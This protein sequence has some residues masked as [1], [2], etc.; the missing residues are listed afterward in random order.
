MVAVAQLVER[1]FVELNVAGS[2]PVS[3]P[4]SSITSDHILRKTRATV[5]LER[6]NADI[7]T[8]NSTLSSDDK[9]LCELL[10]TEIDTHLMGAESKVWHAHPVWFLDGNPIVGYARRKNDIQLLFWSGQSFQSPGLEVEGSFKAAQKRYQT[11]DDVDTD[12]LRNW[13]EESKHVQ[14][15]YKNIVKRKGELIRLHTD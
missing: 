8:Y 11:I 3:H 4:F 2:S 6:M 15:D 12:A 13:L 14:W 5:I 9:K 1:Q 7:A 10:A